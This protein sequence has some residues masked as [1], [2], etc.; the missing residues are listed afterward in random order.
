MPKIDDLKAAVDTQHPHIVCIVE[1]W[2]SS[3]I[4]DNELAI[5]DYQVFRLDRNRHGGGVLMYIHSSLSFKAVLEGPDNL[6]LLVISVTNSMSTSKYCVG[7]FYRP[8]SSGS[9]SLDY[10]YES[11]ESLHPSYFSNFVLLGDFNTDF[12][13]HSHFLYSRLTN[14]LHSFSLTQVVE[15]HTHVSPNGNTSLIDLALISNMSQFQDCETIPI[16]V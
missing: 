1:T 9:Q 8:P 11:L 16:M 15:G 3:E 6:E 13:T 5:Q 7:L 2:L 10:L 14:I 4:S 12:C